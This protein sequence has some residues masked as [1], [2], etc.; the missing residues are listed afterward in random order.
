MIVNSTELQNNFWEIFD[1][2]SQEDIIITRNGN[3]IAKL[4]AIK[5]A[6]SVSAQRRMFKMSSRN[7]Q[8]RTVTAS[9]K[10]LMR[11]SWS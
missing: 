11:S 1:I 5:E 8:N 3:A 7:K 10:H 2:A 9:G 4:S 6:G